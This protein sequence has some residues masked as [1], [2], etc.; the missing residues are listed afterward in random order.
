MTEW[1]K[2]LYLYN[3]EYYGFMKNLLA[4]YLSEGGLRSDLR[5]R[6]FDT[7]YQ[8]VNVRHAGFHNWN[9]DCFKNTLVINPDGSVSNCPN[10]YSTESFGNIYTDNIRD[11]LYC[12]GRA[13]TVAF[14]KATFCDDCKWI[15]VCNSGCPLHKRYRLEQSLDVGTECKAFF[16]AL[17]EI[18][19]KDLY[20]ESQGTDPCGPPNTRRKGGCG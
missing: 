10:S 12:P 3:D 8:S 18:N 9:D 7:M 5:L 6:Y 16:K 14:Q 17:S 19:P 4:A 1:N 13:K 20:G 11:I 15:T 2:K